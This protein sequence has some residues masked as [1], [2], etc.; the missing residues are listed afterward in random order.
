MKKNVMMVLSVLLGSILCAC[1]PPDEKPAAKAKPRAVRVQTIVS[2]DLPVTVNAVG[3]LAPDRE[4]MVSAEVPGIIISYKTDV[5]S[6]VATGDT[7]A[8]LDDADYRLALKEAE[9]NLRTARIRL[10]VEKNAFARAQRLLP[11]KAITPELYDKAEAAYAAAE[12]SVARLES[13]VGMARRRLQKTTIT[14]PFSG[15][16]TQRFVEAGQLI[17]AGNPVMTIADMR[18]MRVNIYIN[19]MDYVHLEKSDPVS[20]TVEAYADAIY[21]GRV[22]T[23]GIQADAR[24]NTFEVEILVDN[25]NNRLKAGLTARVHIRTRTIPNAIMVP[26]HSILFRE[27][28]REVFVIDKDNL[29]AVRSVKLGRVDGSQVRI[30]EGLEPGETLVI[31]GGQYLKPGDRVEVAP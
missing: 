5:G 12:A 29:A 8:A 15:H 30:T 25:P 22:D 23:I 7:L 18:A 26:Q 3:R 11:E 4:V 20:I 24:T 13:L 10:P 19:E 9:A 14:A 17:A 21:R 27:D 6:R 2:R 16:V 1:Q 31:S 28:R